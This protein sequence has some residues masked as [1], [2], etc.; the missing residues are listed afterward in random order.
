MTKRLIEHHKDLKTKTYRL[1]GFSRTA[2]VVLLALL[3]LTLLLGSHNF[4][5]ESARAAGYSDSLQANTG[6]GYESAKS[7]VPN[8]N[9][10]DKVDLEGWLLSRPDSGIGEWKVQKE[11]SVTVTLIS[12]GSTRLDNGVPPVGS[13]IKAEGIPNG[14]N[15]ILATRIRINDYEADE[16]VVRLSEGAP[17]SA[18]V[19][20][21]Y[22]LQAVATLLKSGR[23][24]LFR[25]PSH[26][27]ESHEI[28]DKIKAT[29]DGSILWAELNYV[30]SAPGGNPFKIWGWGGS[31]PKGYLNQYAFEQVKLAAALQHYSGIGVKIA[32][33]DT[34]VALAHPEFKDRLLPGIDM[35]DENT[36]P[37]DEGPGFAWGHGT[38]IAGIIAQVAPDTKIIPVRILD[39]NGRGNT[40]TLAYA[41]EWAVDQGA[42]VINLSLGTTYFSQVLQDVIADAE[43]K[44]VIIVA[45]AGNNNSDV[46]QY[47]AGFEHVIS[48]SAVDQ[49][50]VKAS[51][52]NYGS[53]VDVAAPG[54]G[55]TSTITGTDGYGYASW[56]GTSMATAFVSGAAA[57]FRQKLPETNGATFE[58]TLIAKGFNIDSL[59]SRSIGRLLDVAKTVGA[60]SGNASSTPTATSTV[61]NATATPVSSAPTSTPTPTETLSQAASTPTRTP[62]S[63]IGTNGQAAKVYL[64]LITK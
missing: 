26:R 55:I 58:E 34:G 52:S 43:S 57:L 5:P 33:L 60:S 22:G 39:S 10:D 61:T 46:L 4:L 14:N 63:D 38:H 27:G 23:I 53:W 1:P 51:F 56:S 3:A 15:T 45:A 49:S 62:T 37:E 9:E 32:L 21:S 29:N 16:I 20:S 8:A 44:G 41:I 17:V 12:D 47:P 2:V 50:N 6:A 59:N 7:S 18:T 48:V 35:I 28:L 64:P 24:Y 36:P 54:L 40:F 31:D 30:G 25:D 19:A 11:K 42:D 13:W